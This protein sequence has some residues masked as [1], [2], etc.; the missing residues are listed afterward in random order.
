MTGN[1]V[2]EEIL[3][4][5]RDA[6]LRKGDVCVRRDCLE[7]AI[8]RA[9]AFA[10][11]QPSEDEVERDRLET[12]INELENSFGHGPF[13]DGQTRDRLKVLKDR[14]AALSP[15]QQAETKPLQ[16]DCT[17]LL[18]G[19]KL[20]DATYQQIEEALD[21]ADAPCR[22][23]DGK[24]LSLAERVS[25]LQTRPQ[26]GMISADRACE[27]LQSLIDR[28]EEAPDLIVTLGIPEAIA[29]IRKEA[30]ERPQAE[31][32]GHVPTMSLS[33]NGAECLARDLGGEKWTYAT[34]NP[35]DNAEVWGAHRHKLAVLER[36]D[37]PAKADMLA[38]YLVNVSPAN[39]IKFG[40]YCRTIQ[41][42]LAASRR[43]YAEAVDVLRDVKNPA[44]DACLA[45]HP[46]AYVPR[47]TRCGPNM[48]VFRRAR[49]L[50][51][52]ADAKG[53]QG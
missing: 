9:F 25:T 38:L 39:I 16:A 41:A 2:T 34:Q 1:R 42:A 3:N 6:Y 24:W 27:I 49:A 21:R 46:D 14:L 40:V 35:R 10:A 45:D 51:A 19:G 8:E 17:K 11:A 20:D 32:T 52:A 29:T 12:E 7:A 30:G 37:D 43:D 23:K 50:V 44:D 36:T 18:P 28:Y 31:G 22:A 33:L 4:E 15:R 53:G 26:A 47:L 48:G 13:Q 5:A